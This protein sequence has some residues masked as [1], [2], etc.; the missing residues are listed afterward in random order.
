[1]PAA[2]GEIILIYPWVRMMTLVVQGKEN[3]ARQIDSVKTAGKDLIGYSEKNSS[4]RAK[5]YVH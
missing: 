3:R 2:P 1:M 5:K 4:G